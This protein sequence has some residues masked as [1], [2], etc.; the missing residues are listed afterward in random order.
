MRQLFAYG[1]RSYGIDLC[2][3]MALYVDQALVVRLLEPGMMGTYVVALSLSRMLNAF[4]HFRGDGPVS[5]GSE[6]PARRS[7]RDDQ[8]RHAD[9]HGTGHRGRNW[10][11]GPGAAGT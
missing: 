1:I 3:T 7:R 6:L 11:C 9:E 5:Q 4:P 2:G 10:H 8:P